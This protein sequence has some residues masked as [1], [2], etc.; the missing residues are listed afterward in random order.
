MIADSTKVT[1]PAFEWAIENY[2]LTFYLIKVLSDY[3]NLYK[4]IWPDIRE[5]ISSISKIKCCQDIAKRLLL[6]HKVY[7][8]YVQDKREKLQ[9]Y[10]Q[11]VK[12]Q[13]QKMKTT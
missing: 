5:R 7:G 3:F 2:K 13:V 1:A 4:K 8:F 10:G 11:S 6:E 9:A 12:H